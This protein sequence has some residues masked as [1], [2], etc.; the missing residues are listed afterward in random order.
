ME[1]TDRG[2]LGQAGADG[3]PAAPG[4]PRISEHGLIGDLRTAA[5]VTTGGCIDWFCAPRFD[6]PSVFGSLLDARRGGHWEITAVS[7]GHIRRRQFY[8]PDT[9]ILITRMHTDTGIVEIHD[10]MPIVRAH[11]PDHVQRLTRRVVN[12]RGSVDL[13]VRVAPRFDYGRER[14][15]VERY[16]EG[17]RFT[18]NALSLALRSTVP[19]GVDGVDV[20]A[21]F[22]LEKGGTALFVLEPGPASDAGRD[23]VP[24]PEPSVVHELFE[25]TVHFWRGWLKQSMYTGRWREMVHRSALTLKL[26]THEPT[27]AIVA[28]PTLGLPE[29]IGGPRNWD[30]RYVWVRDAAFSLYALLRLGFTDEADAFVGWLTRMLRSA[31]GNLEG[32]P[33]R[34][35]YSIDGHADLPEEVLDH[36]EGYLGSAPIR[37]GNAA[38]GQVQL[39]IYGELIDSV[40]LFNKYGAGISH[41]AWSD[42][43]TILE[44][45][46]DHWDTPDAGIWETRA[47]R[48]NHTYSRLMS[49]VAM[50]RMVRMARQRGLPGDLG[51]WISARDSIY[52]QIM[53]RGWHEG[54]GT[55]TRTIAEDTPVPAAPVLDASLLLMPMVKFV[56]P[57][58]PRFLGLIEAIRERLVVD[59]LVFRYDPGQAPDGLEGT[60]GTFSICSFWWVEALTRSGQLEE[61]RLAL[62]KMFTYSSHVGLYAEQIG[63]S[64]EHLGNFPQAFTHLALI[65]A[66]I[67]LN[68]A[69][70]HGAPPAR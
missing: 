65:S 52:H 34:V 3:E 62:E 27:G 56:A 37:V 55:F 46:I 11:D 67:N 43:C 59:S 63:L 42:L 28:A 61:A 57:T 8:F 39:D 70:D 38:S 53:D 7:A 45:L 19:L 22:T 58:D 18:G 64:G 9:N 50:E 54:A 41:E 40:Y 5:L 10:F 15:R 6:S 29:R 24:C 69:L 44:W 32:G 23:P 68:R 47:G 31:C 12:V 17:V 20:T 48:V 21:D 2:P 25:Q 26:L 35:M 51:R 33:L 49:W 4:Y 60:E 36:W 14:H 66:A 30:Y 1:P 16:P 13:A